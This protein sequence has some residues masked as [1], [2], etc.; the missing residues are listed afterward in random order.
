M[1][2]L[3][4]LL[5]GAVVLWL[6]GSPVWSSRAAPQ[7]DW[8]QL[9]ADLQSPLVSVRATVARR[10]GQCGSRQAVDALVRALNDSSPEVRREAAR[11]LGRIRDA[12][13][14]LP[15]TEALNDPDTNVRFYAAWALGE[16]KDGRAAEA[17][18]RA[19]RDPEWTVR[20]QAA[21]ALKELHDPTLLP[22]LVELLDD[23]KADQQHVAWLVRQLAGERLQEVLKPALKHR[24]PEVRLR[25]WQLLDEAQGPLSV[26]TLAAALSDSDRQVR[27]FAVAKLREA[28]GADAR[29]ALQ[30]LLEGET[31][32]EVRRAAAEAAEALSPLKRLVAWWGFDDPNQP[33]RDQ[34]GNGND[35]QLL[36]GSLVPGR[37]GTALRLQGRGGVELGHPPGAVV[38]DREFTVTAWT[39][40]DAKDGV[41]VA[42][43]GAFCGFSLYV[44]DGRPCFGIHRLRDGPAYV[45][46]GDQPVVGK[47]VHLAGV[48]RKGRVELYVNGELVA[49]AR[50][51]GLIPS[52][53]G[54]GMEIGFDS[55]NSPAELTTPLRGLID[56]VRFFDAALSAEEIAE[57]MKVGTKTD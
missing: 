44:K 19:L 8:K 28:G 46:R 45:A 33:A 37:V 40:C 27:L 36:A 51:P 31:D 17:L 54:Q 48:V 12:H 38:Q 14:V 29:A 53:C 4:V 39:R 49:T 57:V 21:W 20:D 1:R 23:E 34:T 30:R 2:R 25:A 3:F 6:V 47:W 41:V 55:G 15:L 43:G 7:P 56:D 13:A 10:L 16:L 9:V 52:N 24:R 50:T 5:T 35:G 42:R 11:A 18:L 32:P 26:E 22:K